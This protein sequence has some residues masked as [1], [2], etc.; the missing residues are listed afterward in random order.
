MLKLLIPVLGR[1]GALEAARHAAFLFAEKCVAQVELIE[2]L[3]E[4]GE[5]RAV[6]FQSRAA[7]R[8]SEKLSMRDALT[9]TCAVL[10]DA[11]VPYRWKRVFGAPEKTIAA[12]A[13]AHDSDLVIL[14]AS[15]LGFFRRWGILARLWRLSPKPI[16]MLH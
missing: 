13:A 1:E 14:D 12:Y 6:A 2:V 9:R 11:G 7:L 3:E 10:D 8:R 16:T 15:G 4:V 5:G